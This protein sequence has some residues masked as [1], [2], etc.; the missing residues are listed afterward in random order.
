MQDC[1]KK[2]L[3]CFFFLVPPPPPPPSPPKE[4]RAPTPPALSYTQPTPEPPRQFF[5]DGV[6]LFASGLHQIK[7]R[8]QVTNPKKFKQPPRRTS[9]KRNVYLQKNL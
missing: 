2:I 1:F 4:E 7:Q 8:L 9:R 6:Y 3:L 5:V